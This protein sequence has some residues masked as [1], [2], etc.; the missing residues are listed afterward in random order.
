MG[1]NETILTMKAYAPYHLLYAISAICAKCNNQNSV[2]SPYEC[3]RL[4]KEKSLVQTI[5]QMAVACVNN[6]IDSESDKY[7]LDNKQFIPQ[8]WVKSKASINAINSAVINCFSFNP[9]AKD[10]A[11]AL[12]IDA[13]HFSYRV[14]ADD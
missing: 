7:A 1:L 13:V 11:K 4:A 5:V 9:Y 14:T 8:N 12:K 6:A 10:L 3:L 2:P